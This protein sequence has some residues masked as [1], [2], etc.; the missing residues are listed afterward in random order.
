MQARLI[1]SCVPVSMLRSHAALFHCDTGIREKRFFFLA[2]HFANSV[3]KKCF[4]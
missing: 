4:L 2:T 3:D 1:Q